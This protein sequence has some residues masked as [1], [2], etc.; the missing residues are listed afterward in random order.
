M[1]LPSDRLPLEARCLPVKCE[2][3]WRWLAAAFF[4]LVFSLGL[5]TAGDYGPAWDETDEMDILRMNLWEYAR[6]FGLDESAFEERAAHKDA[7]ALHQLAPISQSVEMDHGEAAFYPMGW[8]VMNDELSPAQRSRIWHMGCWALFTLGAFALYAV[9]RELGLPRPAALLGPVF[10]LLSPRFFAQGHYNNKDIALM[11]LALCALWQALAL[12]RRPGLARGLCFAA[13]GALAANTKVAGAAIWCVCA[14]FVLI[15]LLARRRMNGRMWAVGGV[16]LAAFLGFYALLTP[17]LWASPGAFV[18]YLVDNALAFQRWQ[19]YILFRGTVFDLTRQSLPWYYLPY[20]IFATTP[21]WALLM[22]ALGTLGVCMAA[23]KRLRRGDMDGL[24]LLLP[25]LLWVLP[26]GFAVLTRTNV[27]NGWRHFYFLYGPMLALAA[28]GAYALWRKLARK[29]RA[30]FAGMLGL[31]MAFSAAGIAGQHPYQ[32]AY[33]QPLVQAC[34]TDYN[35][36]DYWNVSV[37][38]A[39][40]ELLELEEG[41]LTIA[42]AD[43]WAENGLAKALEA[44]NDGQRARVRVCALEDA[45]FVLVNPTYLRFSRAADPAERARVALSSYGQCI[46][47]IY[48]QPGKGDAQP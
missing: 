7:T 42:P 16:T 15:D 9:C 20:M 27:Y 45:R 38:D 4:A 28:W 40:A 25:V 12:A 21:L 31:C 26:L 34:G 19:N 1:R 13:F 18:R 48:E 10:L 43:A 29:R 5:F 8:A 3:S 36:L 47:Y 35:E 23:V 6:A 30:A 33:Y 32:Y 39:L 14:L 41:E 2:N 24:K 46:M 22:I 11:A 37:R 44:L 17:A